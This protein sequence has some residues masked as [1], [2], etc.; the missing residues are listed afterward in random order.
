[1]AL[2]LLPLQMRGQSQV[3]PT[4]VQSNYV[5]STSALIQWELFNSAGWT[6]T[7]EYASADDGSWTTVSGITGNQHLLTGLSPVTHYA[8]RLRATQ[9]SDVQVSNETDFWTTCQFSMPTVT[10]GSDDY[11]V[12]QPDYSYYN[13]SYTQQLFSPTEMGGAAMTISSIAA[14][15][16]HSN[17]MTRNVTIYMGHTARDEFS[18]DTC[19]VPVD[20]LTQVFSGTVTWH[21]LGGDNWVDVILDTPFQYNGTDNLVLAIKDQTGSW[22]SDERFYGHSAGRNASVIFYTDEYEVLPSNP[23]AGYDNW[24]MAESS[25]MRSNIKFVGGC[26]STGCTIPDLAVTAVGETTATLYCSSSSATIEIAEYSPWES[27]SY[28]AVSGTSLTGLEPYTNYV[29]RAR[30]TCSDGTSDYRYAYFRTNPPHYNRHIYVAENEGSAGNGLTWSTAIA[31]LQEAIN[32]AAQ[33]IALGDT[34]DVWVA[35]GYY[36]NYDNPNYTFTLLPGVEIYG[37]FEGDEDADY[38]LS[39]RSLSGDPNYGTVL[40]GQSNKTVIYHPSSRHAVVDG[41]AIQNGYGSMG[42]GINSNG[43]IEIRNCTFLNNYSYSI[44]GAISIG[45]SMADPLPSVVSHCVIGPNSGQGSVVQVENTAIDNCLIK[46]NN[47]TYNACV[48]L[49]SSST[50]DH[51]S[52]VNN[53]CSGGVSIVRGASDASVTNSILWSS[54]N[55]GAPQVNSDLD[56]RYCAVSDSLL[57][58]TNASLHNIRLSHNNYASSSNMVAP[59]FNNPDQGDYTLMIGSPCIDAAESTSTS[60]FDLLGNARQVGSAT[61]MGCYESEGGGCPVVVNLAVSE[62]GYLSATLTWDQLGNSSTQYIIEYNIYG[63]RNVQTIDGITTTQYTFTNL[64]GSTTY[65]ARVRS[66]CDN[67]DTSQALMEVMFTIPCPYGGGDVVL[68]QNRTSQNYL[69]THTYYDYSCTQ[70]IF[71]PADMGNTNAHIS[72]ISFQYFYNSSITRNITLYL[73]HS[74]RTSFSSTSD[75]EDISDFTPVFHGNFTFVRTGDY[76]NDITFSEPF[77]YDGVSSLV[78]VM[79]DSTGS[80]ASG[81][82]RFYSQ[83]VDFPSSVYYYRDGSPIN[84]DN[85]MTG[86]PSNGLLNMRN[87]VRFSTMCPEQSCPDATLTISDITSNSAQ[88]TCT[89]NGESDGVTIEY[90][91]VGSNDFTL[92]GNAYGTYTLSGLRPYTQYVVR[93][94]S[95]C[96]TV[97]GF[98]TFS[99]FRTPMTHYDRHIYVTATGTGL[100]TSW[101]DPT[102]LQSAM[103]LAL[104]CYTQEN[105]PVDVWVAAG[106]YYGD[107]TSFIAYTIPPQVSIYGGFVGNEPADYNVSLRNLSEHTTVLNGQSTR[108]IMQQT[109]PGA[110]LISGF[111]F[112]NAYV[113]GMGS[114]ASALTSVGGTMVHDCRFVNNQSTYSPVVYIFSNN[115]YSYI[116]RCSFTNNQCEGS[117]IDATRTYIDNS[118]VAGNV[119]GYYSVVNLRNYS[120]MINTTVANNQSTN[121][122]SVNNPSTSN[123]RNSIIWGNATGTSS[124]LSYSTSTNIHHSAVEGNFSAA[125]SNGNISLS[126]DNIG[127]VA[128]VNYPFFESPEDGSYD[129]MPGSACIDACDSTPSHPIDLNGQPR[130]FGSSVD[131]GCLENQGTGCFRPLHVVVSQVGSSSAIISWDADQNANSTI[132]EISD[133]DGEAW[134]VV[135]TVSSNEYLLTTLLPEAVYLVRLKSLCDG[136]ESSRY[137]SAIR[138]STLCPYLLGDLIIGHTTTTN[139]YLP[140]N[141]YYSYSY[142]QQIFTAEEM[143]DAGNSLSYIGFQYDNASALTRQMTIY[144]G[145]TSQDHFASNS[146]YVSID[147]LHQVFSGVVTFERN[148]DNNWVIIRFDSIFQYSHSSN[149]VVAV[150]DLT[151]SYTSNGFRFNT[152]STSGAYRGILINRDGSA[153]DLSNLPSG[154]LYSYRNNVRFNLSCPATGCPIPDLVVSDITTNSAQLHCI[155]ASSSPME[156]EL[157]DYNGNATSIG[158]STGSYSLANLNPFR[159]Y[160]VRARTLCSDSYSEWKSVSFTTLIPQYDRIYVKPDVSGNGHADS[161][162]NATND[163]QWAIDAANACYLRGDSVPDIWVASGIY[164]GDAGAHSAYTL[165]NPVKLYGGFAGDEPATYDLSLRNFDQNKTVLDGGGTHRV[166]YH[167]EPG[168]AVIDGFAFENGKI[169]SINTYTDGIV[170]IAPY[171]SAIFSKGGLLIR[172]CLFDNDSAYYGVVY[173]ASNSSS[174]RTTIENCVFRDNYAG[175]YLLYLS[176][177]TIS[178]TLIANNTGSYGMVYMYTSSSLIENCD[179]VNNKWNS[180]FGGINS[181]STCQVLNTIIWGNEMSGNDQNLHFSPSNCA[182]VGAYSAS[183]SNGNISLTSENTSILGPRFV[184]PTMEVGRRTAAEQRYP[185][186]WQL[187]NGSP[188]ANRGSASATSVGSTD[189][190]GN[191]RV[192]QD[193][194]DMGCYESNFGISSLPTYPDSIVYVK[195]IGQGTQDGSSWDNAMGDLTTALDMAAINHCNVW[196]A[197]GTYHGPATGSNAFIIKPSVNVYGGFAG[198]EPS[199]F[200]LS[201][202]NFTQYPTVL[203]GQHRQR[204]L[205]QPVNFTSTTSCTWDGFTITNGECESNSS[206]NYNDGTGAYLMNYSSLKNCVIEGNASRYGGGVYAYGYNNIIN[207]V[208]RNNTA[209]SSGGGIYSGGSNRIVGCQVT[210]NESQSYGGGIYTD[211]SN[212]TVMNCVIADNSS[213]Y[214][215]GGLYVYASQVLNCVIANNNSYYSGGGIYNSSSVC[216][217]YNSIIWGNTRRYESNNLYFGYNSTTPKLRYCAVEDGDTTGNCLVLASGNDGYNASL[218]YVRFIDPAN[219]DYHLHVSSPCVDFGLNSIAHSTYDLDGNPRIHGSQ[220]D[221]GPYEVQEDNNCTAPSNLV[222]TN[223]TSNAAT[224]TWHASNEQSRWAVTFGQV[225]Q[226]DSIIFTTDTVAVLTGLQFNRTYSARVRGYCGSDL[227]VFSIPVNFTTVCDSSSLTP[228]SPITSFSPS[229]EIVYTE[230]V[231]FVWSA[232]SMATS[233]DF[234]LWE[235]GDTEPTTPTVTGLTTSFLNNRNLPHYEHGKTYH[236]KVVAWN[237]CLHQASTEQT[238][239]TC[240]L[241]NL[242]VTSIVNSTPVSN[243]TMTVEWTVRNDGEGATP[244]G[245]T[246]LDYI[247]IS[248]VNEIG[249]GFLYNVDEV[250]LASENNLQS[251]APGES[252]TNSTQVTLPPDYIGNYY[253]FV[254]SDQYN[255]VDIDYSPTGD[256]VP[257]IPYN[258]SITGTPYPFLTSS[259]AYWPSHYIYS[260]MTETNETDNFFYKLITILPPP[261]PDLQ[262]THISHPTN[263][264]SNTDVT[265]QWTVTN[266]GEAATVSGSWHDAVYLS[267]EQT[268]NLSTAIHLATI[269]HSESN[270]SIGDSYTQSASVRLPIDFMGPYYFFV[271][272][273]INNSVYEGLMD[274]NNTAIS[275]QALNVTLTPPA[276]LTVTHISLPTDSVSNNTSYPITFTVSNIGV[277]ETESDYWY[278]AV[279]L[280]SDSVLNISNALR[281][282]TWYHYGALEPDSSYSQL[283]NITIPNNYMG[284]YYLFVVTDCYNDVFEYTSESNNTVRKSTPIVVCQPDLV[285]FIVSMPTTI[286]PNEEFDIVWRITNQG[287]G[288][289]PNVPIKCNFVMDGTQFYTATTTTALGVGESFEHTSRVKLNCVASQSGQISIVVDPSNAIFEG[290]GES[291]NTSNISNVALA[292]PDLHVSNIVLPAQLW[293]GSS[294][295]VSWNLH[296]SGNGLLGKP[297]TTRFYLS[298]SASTYSA[299]DALCSI[300]DTLALAPGNTVL[301]SATITLPNG[302]QGTY[303]LHIVANA[304]NAICEGANAH[305]NVAHSSARTVNLTPYPDLV[306]TAF[307]VPDTVNVGEVMEVHYNL[308]NQG[309]ADIQGT[310]VTTQFYISNY[311]SFNARYATLLSTQQSNLS[312]AVGESISSIASVPIPNTTSAGTRYIYAVVD[313]T[314]VL[315]EYTGET[316]NTVRSSVVHVKVYPLDLSIESIAGPEDVEWGQTVSYAVTVRNNSSVPTLANNWED[317]LYLSA[318]NVLGSNDVRVQQPLRGHTLNAGESYTL[319]YSVTIPYGASSTFYLIGVAD[320]NMTNPDINTANN[321]VAKPITVRSVPTPDLALSQ[322]SIIDGNVVSGQA[323]R[324]VYTVTN[325]SSV[326]IQSQSWNDKLFFATSTTN[327][328]EIG[329]KSMASKSLAAGESYTDTLSFTLPIPNNGNLN[330]KMSVNASNLLFESNRS[331]NDSSF[332]TAVTLPLPGDLVVRN[333]VVPDTLVSGSRLHA[334]WTVAN[335]GENTLSGNNLRSL[336]YL[337]TDTVFDANDKMIGSVTTPSIMLAPGAAISQSASMHVSGVNEGNYHIIVKTDVTNAFNEVNDNN[338]S[339]PAEHPF[340][341]RVKLLPFNTTVTD[342]LFNNQSN[343]YK[344]VVGDETHETVRV[345]LSSND[346]LNGALNMLYVTHNNIGNNLNY[347]YSTNGQYTGT[348]DLYIPSTQSGFYGVNVYGSTPA[349]SAQVTGIRADILPFE[350]IECAPAA[351]GNTGKTTVELTG[352]RFRPDMQVSLHRG[353]DTIR[354]EKLEYD[355]YYRVFVTFDLTGR[356]TGIYSLSAVNYCEGEA[357]LNN[358]FAIEPGKP[359]GLLTKI[360]FPNAPRPNRNIV[361]MVEFSNDGNVDIVNPIVDITS[362]GGAFIAT[363]PEGLAEENTTL[364]LPLNIEGEPLGVLRPGA[365]GVLNI[366]CR[367]AGTLI[368]RV[369]RVK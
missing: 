198:N 93:A 272:T 129:L 3:L 53:F 120:T 90:A 323:A 18:S 76:W 292:T 319:N 359:D 324:L 144:L 266:M 280:S 47:C 128:G 351:A 241:P 310:N 283:R 343:D 60:S 299:S 296:N 306:M 91:P 337:S 232:L 26:P 149:L 38:D 187:S 175:Y 217:I 86:S 271:T 348:P 112:A 249:G 177:A 224:I 314:D 13:Y 96:D 180:Y 275:S 33:R 125:G 142:T 101:Q 277:S 57:S 350:L 322:L 165:Y 24:L 8:V 285:P 293:S 200:D 304:N 59:F 31:D 361:L 130:R 289:L 262:V 295:N 294:I 233:Y 39:Q 205:Y 139:A 64:V 69:P 242:H 216:N 155:N 113:S 256:T 281:L 164:S 201:Q 109:T 301:D 111:T 352:S 204:V 316:N 182:I 170:R 267:S 312:L 32:I 273:D 184:S 85:P 214:F 123:I 19:Y 349:G 206:N 50:M 160:T 339:A 284:S 203:D 330:L 307:Q 17:P 71:T 95:H 362:L 173:E 51:C 132:V 253:I 260:R 154:S 97:Q 49:G 333:V 92:I 298:Q 196:V 329:S 185:S 115:D 21:S 243:Q 223:V 70:Q 248:G 326:D 197:N 131:M 22:V 215:G 230:A 365:R 148:D 309:V 278:D 211:N 321:M 367:T 255:A 146:D 116:S 276:D 124:Q 360:T 353:T 331:N 305:S 74:S 327:S 221:L 20:S 176:I 88:V 126:S 356:D 103:D 171:G 212:D 345:H 246:W 28:S 202:R 282:G 209:S 190:A 225:G 11:E 14:Q 234:Y 252:Y 231:N 23:T 239:T 195:Q 179:I 297:L 210:N 245:Q 227:S 300:V 68:D 82:P 29:L 66:V 191:A 4:E 1:M 81:Y 78:L 238:F 311:A 226:A 188:C 147:S 151:G 12:Y 5:G 36:Y 236:W 318:D 244:P 83:P 344:I 145:E 219:G 163:L 143:A 186:S 302:I 140:T 89:A 62:I 67:G 181:G 274:V 75:F 138:F 368:F 288:V 251:L 313:A 264:F 235:D 167:Y 150:A 45:S 254:N 52:V 121:I 157:V 247:W 357:V 250:L 46:N 56:V 207:C 265:V 41:F 334:S 218:Y 73:G 340:Y 355:S 354:C 9:G 229:N 84:L 366:H 192:Q 338:N 137:S 7:L 291:N 336:V 347:T 178:N 106:T 222:V 10:I 183:G 332:F 161:W 325:N 237:E 110:S 287:Q 135:D 270:L 42:A 133:N 342:S 16:R 193:T 363:T 94:Y 358:A 220:I 107:T 58:Q 127:F 104:A 102:D 152:H 156:I 80:Y 25:S 48:V 257:P 30:T 72:G 100:G 335:I 346:S 364:R 43:N 189:L 114:D 136:D 162:A 2:M 317:R 105:N 54:S 328:V 369:D 263:A 99:R 258:P 37:G 141:Q 6:V 15:Y 259:T 44:G 228:L 159:T 65:Q 174:P 286:N 320:Y 55:L 40:S 199:T 98:G 172:N 63:D 341:L 290:A 208:V 119:T 169:L 269:Q 61:D 315:Y 87:V 268:F 213:H 27:L 35:N 108:R 168:M 79:V 153:Y 303:Y 117:V 308:V 261:S 279:Y 134:N 34:V 240:L 158:T 194:I 122:A 166:M 77:H 118:L